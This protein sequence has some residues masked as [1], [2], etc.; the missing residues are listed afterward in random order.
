MSKVEGGGVRLTLP[1]LKASCNYFSS[2][3]LGLK[4]YSATNTFTCELWLFI[5][6]CSVDSIFI[7]VTSVSDNFVNFE[8]K[9]FPSSL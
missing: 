9:S 6:N 4:T 2:R 7:V 5:I 1:P 8:Y 3:L